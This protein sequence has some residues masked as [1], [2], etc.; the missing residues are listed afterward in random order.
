MKKYVITIARQFGSSGRE[1][2][3]KLAELLGYGFYD[4]QLITLAAQKS[5]LDSGVLSTVDE[6]AVS[7][8][9]YTLALGSSM[10]GNGAEQITLPINDRLFVIQAE[11]IKELASKEQGAVIVGRCADYVLSEHDDL[12]KVFVTADYTTRVKTVMARHNLTEAKAKDAV[13]KTDKRRSNY[14]SYYT[15]EKWGRIDR[16][17]LV[18]STDKLGVEGAAQVIRDY[19]ERLDA[20]RNGK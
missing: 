3:Q 5:G 2:G 18:V 17:D 13:I 7:S 19:V 4:K 6:K 8:L 20:I 9:L 12:V 16:Y 11:I 14:Y 15:G 1:V 10:Y